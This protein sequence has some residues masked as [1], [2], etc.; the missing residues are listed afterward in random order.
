V[1]RA[2][3]Q[4]LLCSW[5]A[6]V[7][8]AA[9]AGTPAPSPSPLGDGN[10]CF[11]ISTI[12]ASTSFG[13]PNDPDGGFF[14][15]LSDCPTQCKKAG[16]SCAKLAK[17]AAACAQRYAD[18][19]ARFNVKVNCD[20]KTG[21]E[22]KTCSTQYK[23]AQAQERGDAADALASETTACTAR[24]TDCAAKCDATAPAVLGIGTLY[25]DLV[26]RD[27]AS[28][29]GEFDFETSFLGLASC[30]KLCLDAGNVC[31]R[32]VA[33]AVTCQNAFAS[34]WIASD[35]RVNCDGLSGSLLRDCKASWALDKAAWLQQIKGSRFNAIFGCVSAESKCAKTCTGQ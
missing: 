22:L 17:G 11:D 14:T 18:D 31:L 19:R 30:E 27:P 23:D 9:R 26:C 28:I 25:T 3:L 2:P 13:D 1:T 7:P 34:D 29:P 24:A 4:L 15:H 21:T 10:P 6:L 12:A 16:V 35:S 32:D 8:L 33:D 5:L 20:G